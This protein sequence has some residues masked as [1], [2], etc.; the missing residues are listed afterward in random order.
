MLLRPRDFAR[1]M[2]VSAARS[3]FAATSE[4]DSVSEDRAVPM[5]TPKYSSRSPRGEVL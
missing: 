4:P 2:A 3:R 5:L 1:Y